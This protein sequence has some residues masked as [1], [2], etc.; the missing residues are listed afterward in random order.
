MSA[1]PR[2]RTCAV[3]Q[4][5]SALGQPRTSRRL[6]D[7]PRQPEAGRPNASTASSSA[8]SRPASSVPFGPAAGLGVGIVGSRLLLRRLLGLGDRL[9]LR[10]PLYLG[11]GLGGRLLLRRRLLLPFLG[12]EAVTAGAGIVLGE[13]LLR[14]VWFDQ[15]RVCDC[16]QA[17]RMCLQRQ[18]NQT[19]RSKEHVADERFHRCLLFN[20]TYYSRAR[21]RLG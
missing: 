6:F 14:R 21:W 2:K 7:S 4:L 11:L 20:G 10:R 19:G 15:R 18:S 5:M 9:L 13:L 12:L 3:Q 1:L 16:C 17:N 8:S